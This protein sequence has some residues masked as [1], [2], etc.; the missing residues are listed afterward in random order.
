MLDPTS[1]GPEGGT[2]LDPTVSSGGYP[3]LRVTEDPY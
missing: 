3:N 2:I 1:R